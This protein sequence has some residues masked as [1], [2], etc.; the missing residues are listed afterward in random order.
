MKTKLTLLGS[1]VGL[2]IMVSSCIKT[3]HKIRIT[4]NFPM[5]LKI[6]CGPADFGSVPNG[7]TTEYKIIPE[8]NN[9]L[10]G[11]I[12]GNVVLDGAGKHNWTIT[13]STGG[14]FD[15]KEDK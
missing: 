6:V 8:G 4:N 7:T 2:M 9:P 10:S 13:I 3:E 15:I 1:I 11:D 5:A 12:N 14:S